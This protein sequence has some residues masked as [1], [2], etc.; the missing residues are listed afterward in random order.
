MKT[1]TTYFTILTIAM[2]T[3]TSCSNDE[4]IDIMEIGDVEAK[5]PK[6]GD[7]TIAQIVVAA[8]ETE[9]PEFTILLGALEYAGLTGT[10]TGGDQYTVFAPT[11]EAFINLVTY[12]N[13]TFEDFDE[14]DPFNEID[15]ILGPGT[16]AAVLKYHVVEGRRGANSVV[17]KK[18]YKTIETLLGA[19]FMVK[20]A[21]EE[22]VEIDAIG[23]NAYIIGPDAVS[24]SNG[25]I[26]IIDAV[27]LPI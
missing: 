17:P 5:S 15:R 23:N 25:I 13:D 8:T 22:G 14:T 4:S 1:L 24:A 26:H 7:M 12:F 18:N 10:F 21:T 6:K 3:F 19:S 9:D 11:D 2:F 27:I 20:A 16:V